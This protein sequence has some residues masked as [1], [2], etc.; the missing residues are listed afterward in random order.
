MAPGCAMPTTG[1]GGSEDDDIAAHRATGT[2]PAPL[3]MSRRGAG[4]PAQ[5][6]YPRPEVQVATVSAVTSMYD[7]VCA[8][9][10]GAGSRMIRVAPLSR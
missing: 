3:S 5:Y 8:A 2:G 4:R 1:R 6:T 7:V 9:S 10:V